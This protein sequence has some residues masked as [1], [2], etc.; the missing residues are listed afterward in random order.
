MAHVG[1]CKHC[2]SSEVYHQTNVYANFGDLTLLPK[3]Y[4]GILHPAQ[5]DV[6][7]CTNCGHTEF[8]VQEEFL[9]KVREKWTRVGE[10][11]P[12]RE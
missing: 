11:L 7:V 2:G 4:N 5:F 9:R 3:V 10:D 1:S 12:V 6:Y 8:F